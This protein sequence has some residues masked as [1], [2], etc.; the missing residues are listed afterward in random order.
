MT[1]QEKIDQM[2]ATGVVAISSDP[3]NGLSRELDFK[4]LIWQAQ[5]KRIIVQCLVHFLD[6]EGLR[7]E[8]QRMLPYSRDMISTNMIPVE[9][10][11]G[12]YDYF[13]DMHREP[14]LIFEVIYDTIMLRDSQGKFNI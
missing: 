8:S 9:G 7:M 4:G 11:P 10:E 12:E 13:I 6:S 1:K 14:Q 3:I 2:V 5:D